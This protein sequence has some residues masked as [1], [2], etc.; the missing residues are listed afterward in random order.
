VAEP[1]WTWSTAAS[2]LGP[3]LLVADG[4]AQLSGL[5]FEDNAA[6]LKRLLAVQT[7]QSDF[8]A[9]PPPRAVADAL[10][11][12]F[13]G[14]REAFDSL[15]VRLAGTAFQR[16]VWAQLRTLPFGQK[17]SYGALAEALGNP[18]AVR[19]VGLANGANPISLVVPCHR[20]IGADG[21]L[22]GYA[23]GLARKRW[24][25]EHEGALARPTQMVLL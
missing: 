3:L 21:A 22:T 13:D 14:A 5:D 18:A 6:R 23:G 7:G 16:R 20:V 10:A 12:Y 24:L 17:T 11:R 9:A 8:V 19:A 4:A 15:T 1:P 25:L 2:P